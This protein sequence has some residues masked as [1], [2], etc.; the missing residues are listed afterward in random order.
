[1]KGAC[2][3]GETHGMVV[4]H[5]A[6]KAVLDVLTGMLGIKIDMSNLEERAKRTERLMEKLGEEMKRRR[7]EEREFREEEI[8][9]IA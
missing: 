4:D 1:M 7:Q 8:S 6:A 2:L 5:R 3:L 9:Y